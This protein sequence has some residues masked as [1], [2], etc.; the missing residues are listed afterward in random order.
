MPLL[1]KTSLSPRYSFITRGDG[2][3]MSG[4]GSSP[5][6]S[7][8]I[9]PVT[10]GQILA[11]AVAMVLGLLLLTF[12]GA[13]S[14]L[15]ILIVAVIIYMLP[16]LAGADLKV[17]A[18][19]GVIF[20]VVAIIFGAFIVGPA[21]IHDNSS[22]HLSE[23]NDISFDVECEGPVAHVTVSYAGTDDLVIVVSEIEGVI[24]RSV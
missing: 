4:F 15:V 6:F 23:R 7:K 14:P 16:H 2:A 17:K 9:G 3:S 21:F 18:G 5:L 24:Y 13:N 12:G 8:E 10:V 19:F 11:M 20:A 22:Q 1:S